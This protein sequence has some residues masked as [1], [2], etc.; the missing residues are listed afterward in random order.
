MRLYDMDAGLC[1]RLQRGGAVAAAERP[2]RGRLVFWFE[3]DLLSSLLAHQGFVSV[4]DTLPALAILPVDIGASI[5]LHVRLS[6]LRQPEW[7]RSV[8]AVADLARTSE[9]W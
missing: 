5:F 6:V 2:A 4:V 8:V 1:K 9:S 3:V 7:V